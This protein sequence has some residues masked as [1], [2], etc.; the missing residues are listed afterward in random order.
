[1]FPA[2]KKSDGS[3]ARL[4]DFLSEIA[5]AYV[6]RWKSLDAILARFMSAQK[7]STKSSSKGLGR[8]R[9]SASRDRIHEAKK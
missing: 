8:W 1:V 7:P 2:R 6:S 5:V 4:S 3:Q 9:E